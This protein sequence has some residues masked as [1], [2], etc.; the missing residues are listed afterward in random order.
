MARRL[1]VSGF[2]DSM[3][4]CTA[5]DRTEARRMLGKGVRT[6]DPDDVRAFWKMMRLDMLPCAEIM[7]RFGVSRQTIYN[8][9][10]KAGGE[11]LPRRRDQMAQDRLTRVKA[12]LS[13]KRPHSPTWIARR[14]RVSVET[15]KKMADEMGVVFPGK[16]QIRPSDEELVKLA[17]G[18]TWYEFADAV[19]MAL[20]SLRTYIYKN[21]EL[22]AEIRKVRKPA[23][24]RIAGKGKINRG[25]VIKLLKEGH[26]A[27]K[28]AQ[29]LKVEQMSVRR[30]IRRFVVE[31]KA[32]D[33]ARNEREI[34]D[35]MANG[36][37]GTICY[38]R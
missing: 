35:L 8:W 27:Y 21:P 32:D 14:T 36:G 31:A 1:Y 9:W 34:A 37:R 16:Y 12:E 6:P 15:V 4:F 33:K 29:L 13:R 28:I 38:P 26:S 2:N 20:S 25:K 19:G 7:Q 5:V 22:A 18:R 17:T 10:Q 30:W 3:I 23:E 11:G 24:A